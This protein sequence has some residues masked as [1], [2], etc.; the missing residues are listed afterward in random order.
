MKFMFEA[1]QISANSA[2]SARNPYPGWMASAPAISAAAMMRGMLRYDSRRRG[3]DAHVV[4]GEP[5]VQRLA[6]RLGVD[7]DRLYAELTTGSDYAQRYFAAIG[8]QDF[9]KHLEPLKSN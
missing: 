3:A 9:L 1:T 6:I 2:F 7:G 4:V 5:D 8:Y